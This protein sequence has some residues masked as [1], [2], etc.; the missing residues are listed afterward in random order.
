MQKFIKTF[1][2]LM[3][4]V[5]T[6]YLGKIFINTDY[7]KIKEIRINGQN[8]MIKSDITN[9]IEKLKE[10]NIVYI[11]TW[12]IEKLLKQDARIKNV[13]IR[14]VYPSRVEINLEER[15]PY[16]YVKKGNDIFLSDEQLNI[17]GYIFE[18]ETK[19][20]PVVIYDENE[21]V[22]KDLKHKNDLYKNNYNKNMK[23]YFFNFKS[24]FKP[25]SFLQEK[26]VMFELK[27]FFNNNIF[28]DYYFK[29]IVDFINIREDG[30]LD[31]VDYKTS[32]IYKNNKLITHSYQLILYAIAL[33]DMGF[34]I[35]SL[36][37]NFL[38]YVRKKKVSTKS[39]K[40]FNVERKTLKDTDIFEDCIINID[41]TPESKLKALKYLYSNLLNII[42]LESFK[43][44][45]GN[46]IPYNY[47]KF[48]C[49]N[50]CSCY[51]ICDLGG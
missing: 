49:E 37:W 10:T 32:T 43:N 22:K 17:F 51:T 11:D 31:I 24:K 42:K 4:F 6:I 2:M 44:I 38:K 28:K 46:K 50:L 45:N 34:K 7:F 23:H 16:V 21:E 48:F 19:N 41:Y 30:S 35:N 8:K 12:K 3:S 13:S 9:K 20:I 36:G 47:N 14:K 25:N 40:Y 27:K 15:V 18:S 1:V 33:E 29:G 39:E 26:T 5:V